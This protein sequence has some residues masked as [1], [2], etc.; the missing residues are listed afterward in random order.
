L[1]YYVPDQRKVFMGPSPYRD[2]ESCGVFIALRAL[3]CFPTELDLQ[4]YFTEL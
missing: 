2:K 4:P 3:Q 1:L